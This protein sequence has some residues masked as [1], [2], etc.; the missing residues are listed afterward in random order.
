MQGH[1]L[2]IDDG[3][4]L[5]DFLTMVLEAEG[6]RVAVCHT[7]AA[8]LRLLE[9]NR[10]D[11]VVTDSFSSSSSSLHGLTTTRVVLRAAGTTPVVLCTGHDLEAEAVRAA[12]FADL[13]L[14][15]FDLDYFDA[16]LRAVMP[17]RTRAEQ[18]S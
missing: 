14:K 15:P 2:V 8:A 10:F 3:V 16:C 13:M 17:S 7:L 18:V 6:Y 12:G 11:L 4:E 5:T 9:M 1:I